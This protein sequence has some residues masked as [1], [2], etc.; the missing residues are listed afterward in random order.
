VNPDQDQAIRA[1][2]AF[3]DLVRDPFQGSA[4]VVIRQKLGRS[5]K[6]LLSGLS[7]PVLKVVKRR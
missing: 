7:G 4:D 1:V 5:Q 3:A 2:V 6:I